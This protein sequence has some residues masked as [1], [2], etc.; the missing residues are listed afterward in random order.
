M[1]IGK[2]LAEDASARNLTYLAHSY[3]MYGHEP[4]CGLCG[5]LN[6]YGPDRERV[7][8]QLDKQKREAEEF[9]AQAEKD[10]QWSRR[11]RKIEEKGYTI[12]D[13]L[14]VVQFQHASYCTLGT[15]YGECSKACDWKVV[16]LV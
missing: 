15:P 5:A 13:Q 7:L 6:S 1:R 9:K 16:E 3:D 8:A 11:G 14:A 10:R 12:K 4:G 2:E